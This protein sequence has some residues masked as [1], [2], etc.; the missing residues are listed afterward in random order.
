MVVELETDFS[1]SCPSQ[2]C[3]GTLDATTWDDAI[4]EVRANRCPDA[5]DLNV[6]CNRMLV[7]YDEGGGCCDLDLLSR[8]WRKV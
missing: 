3:E 8:E 6:I 1:C 2:G 5:S 7:E 4:A